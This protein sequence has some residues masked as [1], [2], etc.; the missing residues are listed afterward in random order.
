MG[1]LVVE[2]FVHVTKQ[3]STH[4]QRLTCLGVLSVHAVE[5]DAERVCDGNHVPGAQ[6]MMPADA[7]DFGSNGLDLVAAVVQEEHKLAEDRVL[8]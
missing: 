3:G 8:L 4:G 2:G 1:D 5:R 6:H 7:A